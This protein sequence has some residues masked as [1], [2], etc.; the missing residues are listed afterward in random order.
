M[1]YFVFS[2]FDW[3]MEFGHFVS[4]RTMNPIRGLSIFIFFS[5]SSVLHCNDRFLLS[6]TTRKISE[7]LGTLSALG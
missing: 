2:D 4:W 5:S 6:Y 7:N 3:N 1:L